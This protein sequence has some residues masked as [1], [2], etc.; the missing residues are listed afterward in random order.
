[1]RKSVGEIASQPVRMCSWYPR[2]IGTS[3]LSIECVYSWLTLLTIEV[4]VRQPC[5]A[6]N[7]G[8]MLPYRGT[9]EGL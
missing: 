1:M 3:D 2:R 8:K 4:G 5:V 9:R 7:G 6:R